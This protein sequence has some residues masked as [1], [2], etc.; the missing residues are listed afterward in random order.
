M[1]RES[2]KTAHCI[3]KEDKV[4]RILFAGDTLAIPTGL[5][6]VAASFMKRLKTALPVDIAH[7]TLTN[8]DTNGENIIAQGADFHELFR[9]ARFYNAQARTPERAHEFDKAIEEFRPNVVITVQDPWQID[10]VAYSK[11]RDSFI[12]IAYLTIEAPEYPVSVIHRTVHG[13]ARKSITDTLSGADVIIPVTPMGKKAL[14]KLGLNPT[15]HVYNGV[16]IEDR[17]QG[18]VDPRDLFGPIIGDDDFLFMTMGVNIDRKK[19]DR[20]V[21]AFARFLEKMKGRRDKYKLYMHTDLQMAGT[22][23]DLTVLIMDL[24]LSDNILVTS[25]NLMKQGLPKQE[26]YMRYAASDCYI[27]LPGGEGFGYGFAEAMMHGKPLIYSTYGGHTAYCR[28]AGLPVDIADYTYARNGCIKWALADIDVAAKAMARMVSEP[29]LRKKLGE[30][31]Y[32]IAEKELSWDVVF[33]RFLEIIQREY[34]R[35]PKKNIGLLRRRIV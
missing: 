12:W 7:V 20:T 8:A 19:L 6:Y 29:K 2:G 30:R 26:L 4:E 32:Q 18:E 13:P 35:S 24:G 15:E 33:P 27:G 28:D 25:N 10:Q 17:F 1:T 3:E 9:G 34:D 21:L 5:G 31:G 23:T 22:G 16:D 14:E 11:Y